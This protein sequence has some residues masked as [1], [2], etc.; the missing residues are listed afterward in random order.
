MPCLADCSAF[1]DD[2][3]EFVFGSLCGFDSP[4][5]PADVMIAVDSSTSISDANYDILM[6]AIASVVRRDMKPTTRLGLLQ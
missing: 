6:N 1:G 3:D 4:D 5:I 2:L